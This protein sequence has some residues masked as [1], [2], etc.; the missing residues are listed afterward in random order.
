[1]DSQFEVVG[2]EASG[3]IDYAIKKVIDV[4][5]E[6]LIAITEGKQKD[7]DDMTS[8]SFR[9]HSIT[10]LSTDICEV[11]PRR[12]RALKTLALNILEHLPEDILREEPDFSSIKS[13]ETI[14]NY[15]PCRECDP[16]FLTEDPP[17]SLILSLPPQDFN[18]DEDLMEET[19][20]ECSIRPPSGI[21]IDAPSEDSDMREVSNQFHKFYDDIDNAEKSGD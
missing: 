4:V 14:T 7:L 11:Q 17:R 13:N 21:S 18:D 8:I 20:Q 15:G 10:N 5:N 2:E 9:L 3:R 16:P 1:M 6:E 19:V 12:N